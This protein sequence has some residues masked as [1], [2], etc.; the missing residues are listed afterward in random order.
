MNKVAITG[1]IGSGKTT[2]LNYFRRAGHFAI[3]S[4][5]IIRSIYENKETRSQLLKKLGIE[6]KNYKEVIIEKIKDLQEELLFQISKENYEI[7]DTLKKTIDELKR[8][9][10]EEL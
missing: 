3:S 1:K 5:F 7:A 4:D 9:L 2:A 10:N 6:K 8:R